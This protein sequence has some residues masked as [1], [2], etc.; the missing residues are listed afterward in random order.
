MNV[1]SHA[2]FIRILPAFCTGIFL[3]FNLP[4]DPAGQILLT[5]AGCTVLILLLTLTN[6]TYAGRHVAGIA[7]QGLFVCL[8]F[9]LT[10]GK[11]ERYSVNHFSR[12]QASRYVITLSDVPVERN[13]KLRATAAVKQVWNGDTLLPAS[14][15]CFIYFP[16][17]SALR[18]LLPGSILLVDSKPREIQPPIRPGQFDFRRYAAIRRVYHTLFLREGEWKIIQSEGSSVV[19]AAAKLRNKLLDAYRRAGLTGQEFAVLSAIV[20]GYDDEIDPTTFNSF[21]ASG[22]IHILCVSGMHVGIVYMAVAW[23]L[24]FLD[25]HKYGRLLK[26][27]LL[28]LIIWFYACL[29][30]LSSSVIRSATMFTFIL[31]GKSFSRNSNIYNTLSLSAICIFM[32][33]DPLMFFEPGL[34]LSFL[35]VA[36]IAYLYPMIQKWFEPDN[37]L[38]EKSWSL[39]AVSLAAQIATAPL[40]IYY[41]HRFPTYFLISNLFMLPLSTVGIFSGILLLL[42]QPYET[43]F[44]LAGKLVQHI[45][46]LLNGIA[47]WIEKL[48]ASVIDGLKPN[49]LEIAIAS[50]MI[51]TII[52]FLQQKN[53]ARMIQFLSLAVLLLSSF[54]LHA[55]N[56]L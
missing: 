15:K 34:Q 56:A 32:L 28:L 37:Y 49:L 17:D 51:L 14:G 22:T 7:Y 54:I 9:F 10:L 47:N 1:F 40:S 12:H 18:K 46:R 4:P 5:A 38:L 29:T 45:F 21:S 20:L 27:L 36:G 25:R 19:A 23:L 16:P 44:L 2:P 39:M 8:G 31:I 43:L 33:F 48:P 52:S 26:V 41:F 6:P 30:G 55:W 42:I 53:P 11:G 50:I 13:G 35:A 3:A 24:S